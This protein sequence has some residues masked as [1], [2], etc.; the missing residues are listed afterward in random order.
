MKLLLV[1]LALSMLAVPAVVH[2]DA[3]P[4]EKKQFAYVLHL[5]PEWVDHS[6][7][8]PR[9]Q[10]IGGKHFAWLL[11]KHKEGKVLFAGRTLVDNPMGIVVL[12]VDSE[13]EARAIM[14]GDAAV[15]EELMMAELHPFQVALQ[16]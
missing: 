6:K 1:G 11:Q 12:E 10:E 5:A 16:R 3:K 4:K 7:W 9:E 14:E 2:Q 15:K 8:T 13:Q